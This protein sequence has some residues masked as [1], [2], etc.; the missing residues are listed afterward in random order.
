M[1]KRTISLLLF[2]L[3]TLT[4][5]L[6]SAVHLVFA[7]VPTIYVSQSGSDANDG[8]T[9]SSAVAT[10]EK[11]FELAPK[12]A[13]IVL[14]G[15][16]YNLG[17][18]YVM[19]SSEYHYTLSSEMTG[20]LSYAGTLTL[21]SDM[22]IENV[23]F[24]GSSTPI[25]VCKG[26]NVTFGKGITNGTKAYIVGG[27]NL[28]SAA[29]EC[30]ISNDYTIEINSGEWQ[31]FFGGNRRASGSCPV[32]MISGDITVKIGGAV[33]YTST[34][35]GSVNT[36]NLSGMNSTSGKLTFIMNS[37]EIK[38]S[39]YIAGRAG[40][41]GD[42]RTAS[43]SVDIQING[44]SF[45]SSGGVLQLCQ[46]TSLKFLGDCSLYV[47]DEATVNLKEIN[48]E[49]AE[50]DKTCDVPPSISE[51]CI[52]FARTVYVSDSG[53]DSNNGTFSDK[54]YK[55]LS[56]AVEKL[57]GEGGNIIVHKTLTIKD[58]TVLPASKKAINVSGG[59]L[60]IN[61]SL[62]ISSQFN[63]DNMTLDGS[64]KIYANSNK[65]TIGK[66]VWSGGTLSVSA[67][68]RD[69]LHSNGGIVTLRGGSYDVV[70]AG[71]LDGGAK[72]V[73]GTKITIDGA[74]VRVLAASSGNDVS[75]TSSVSV[76]SGKITEG[77]YGIWGCD[78]A[79][80]QGD[81]SV[82]IAGGDING[83]ILALDST[84]SGNAAGSFSLCLLGGDIS[85]VS[86]ISGAGFSTSLL[87]IS[88]GVNASYDGFK[89]SKS[90][91]LFVADGGSGDGSS[92][93]S[94]L[95]SLSTAIKILK[96]KGGRIVLCKK[97]TLNTYAEPAH[98]KEILITSYYGGVDYR[99]SAG[100]ALELNTKY[101]AAGPVK[102]DDIII[103]TP[104]KTQLFFG[105]GNPIEFGS[106][107]DCVIPLGTSNYPQVF[108]GT[109]NK[110][111]SISGASVVISGG[112]FKRVAGGNRYSGTTVTGD[113]SV[114]ISGGIIDTY[115]SGTGAGS[116]TGDVFVT[117][118][119]GAVKYEVCGI[120]ATKDDPVSVKGDITLTVNGGDPS[121]KI[122]AA[123]REAY[124]TLDGKYTCHI[125]TNSL[126]SVTDIRGC[127]GVGGNNTSQ[128]IYSADAKAND[129]V[130]GSVSYQNPE[131][132]GADPWVIFHEGYYYMAVTRG[133]SVTL[134]KALT[135]AELGTAE[136]VAVWTASEHTGLANSIW[137]PELHYFSADDFGAE[138]E[139]WYLYIACP[140]VNNNDN[141]YRRCYALRALTD[142]PQGPWG[143]PVD[144]APNKPVQIK[145]DEDNSNWNI[146][147]SVFRI[148]GKIY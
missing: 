92:P 112:R 33:F 66:G 147:P 15:S 123:R 48:A 82:E 62:S 20:K 35:G 137:S 56:Y 111:G 129:K 132:S 81:I 44:G 148:N 76:R 58:N 95:S 22:T 7:E 105:A 143:S 67:S 1:K 11:A 98:S 49:C 68:S 37:G 32:G 126:D 78:K 5:S 141:F 31:H 86:R 138:Y 57:A 53:S 27:H 120:Y 87:D 84:V 39:L 51:K 29:D 94:P 24:S 90:S 28:T 104:G 21:G 118:N 46:D 115:V 45:S 110:S 77:I 108:G 100:A 121:G 114:V 85:G 47:S 72:T 34:T 144:K 60:K 125:N 102:F 74:T 63:L 4:L 116:Y 101:T 139:G 146:G 43:G 117:L 96:D 135:V 9:K 55:T 142:D 122:S 113:V 65:L 14:T 36:N 131:I 134:A 23:A 52:G 140:P 42:G 10:L 93:D 119:G 3:C 136:P 38:G 89:L 54:A 109:N 64:G 61:G 103:K 83:R 69:A 145:M 99:E 12:G 88:D 16:S 79:S 40:T 127:D 107:V 18:N 30:D 59:T 80:V 133:S 6:V 73:S 75:T 8:K 26:H 2:V 13:E 97:V 50:G 19:P 91:V 124:A 128:I 17:K 71:S 106:G 25:I 41:G 70:S 130:S